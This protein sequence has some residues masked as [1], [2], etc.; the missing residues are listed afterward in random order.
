MGEGVRWGRSYRDGVKLER[1][2]GG[3]MREGGRM[4]VVK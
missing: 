1:R 3:E 4:G 2:D